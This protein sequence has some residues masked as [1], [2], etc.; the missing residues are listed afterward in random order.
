LAAKSIEYTTIPTNLL[1]GEHKT[2]A[3]L[4][5]NPMGQVPLLECTDKIA[6]KQIYLSQSIAI[7]EFLESLFPNRCSLIPHDPLEKALAMEMVEVVNSGTQPLQ[8]IMVLTELEKASEG[9]IKAADEAKARNEKGLAALEALVQRRQ[10]KGPYCTGSFAPT[11]VDA[12]MV[13]QLYNARRYG[14]DIDRT[15]PTLVQIEAV[16]LEHPWFRASHPQA[17]PD[18]VLS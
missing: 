4:A 9:K 8:N 16:C 15:C 5:K 7:I 13:P 17:Q 1:A 11:I 2:D 12:C 3:F 18:A 10:G 6:G 14:V